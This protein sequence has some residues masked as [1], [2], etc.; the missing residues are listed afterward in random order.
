MDEPFVIASGATVADVSEKIHTSF[1]KRFRYAK[2]W[3]TSCEYEGQQVGLD[4]ELQD[5]DIIEL[6]LLRQQKIAA[7]KTD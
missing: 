4:H 5:K 7:K 1:L 6:V 2:I 3:G